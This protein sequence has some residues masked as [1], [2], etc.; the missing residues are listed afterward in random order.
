MALR[1][2]NQEFG[3]PYNRR[4]VLESIRLHGPIA[5]GDIARRVGLTVQTVSTI[6]RELEEHGYVLSMREEPRG[7]GL[8]PATLRINPEGGYAVGIH[9]TPLGINAALINLSGDVIESSYREA[10]NATPDHA[11]DLIGAMV[12]ELNGLRPGGRVLGVGMALP[13]PFGVESMSFV[14]P[15]TLAGWKDVALQ[16]RLAASTGLPAFFETDMAAA[17]MG[18]RLYGLGTGYSEYYYLHFGVGLGGVMVHDG[19]ALRGAWGNAGEIGH[20]PVVPGGEPCPCGNRGCL[21][22]Y[23]SLE[24]LRR[25]NISDADWVDEVGP[26]FRNA[27]TIIENLFDPETIIL[28]GL[29]STDLLERLARSAANLPNSISARGDRTTPRVTVARGGQ[30]AVLRGA[31]A[32]AVSGVL[33][34]RFGQIFTTERERG[35]DLLQSKGIAA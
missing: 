4:I 34:P 8:P 16:E 31:A 17:A 18:E 21:E 1:G 35:R 27:I 2:T 29:A 9:V 7:R 26:I 33:S 10:P 6:V 20:I 24:A 30:H 13:G 22:R 12:L 3:R 28:G 14:G 23:L 32:L 11:F 19:S 25:R 15:T 5:R